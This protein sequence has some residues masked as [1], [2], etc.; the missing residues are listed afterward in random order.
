MQPSTLRIITNR[1][2]GPGFA[3]CLVTLT[4]TAVGCAPPSLAVRPVSYDVDVHLDVANHTLS[5]RTVLTLDRL[6]PDRRLSGT[7][8][9]DLKLHPDLTVDDVEV[10]GATLSSH[11]VQPALPAAKD[12]PE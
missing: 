12:V 6:V 7:T 10:T 5:G 3:A 1:C 8:A 2:L 4:A 11:T 9:I